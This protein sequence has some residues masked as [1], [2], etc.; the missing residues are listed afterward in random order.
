MAVDSKGIFT[1]RDTILT[2]PLTKT[3]N[4]AITHSYCALAAQLK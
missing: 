1:D 2:Q 4:D 3:M